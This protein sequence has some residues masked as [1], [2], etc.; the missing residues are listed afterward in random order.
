MTPYYF[1][2]LEIPPAKSRE[3]RLAQL[4]DEIDRTLMSDKFINW[5]EQREVDTINW[6]ITYPDGGMI[7][8]NEPTFTILAGNREVQVDNLEEAEE[9]LWHNHSASNYL[10]TPDEIRSEKDEITC[11]ACLYDHDDYVHTHSLGC[12]IYEEVIKK[13]PK[14]E[15]PTCEHGY[16]LTQPCEKCDR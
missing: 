2:R 1:Q 4:Q 8:M 16:K 9:W 10:K 11:D 13:P 5:A 6:K 14:I 12:R 7:S 15:I 3:F